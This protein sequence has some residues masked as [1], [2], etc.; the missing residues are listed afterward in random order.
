MDE[1]QVLYVRSCV[2][3]SICSDSGSIKAGETILSF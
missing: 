2:E 1:S 3:R